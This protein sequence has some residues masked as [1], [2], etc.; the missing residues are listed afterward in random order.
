MDTAIF[1]EAL[2]ALA[3][4]LACNSYQATIRAMQSSSTYALVVELDLGDELG[5][6]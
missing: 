4:A 5:L 1:L 2:Q 6:T 3:S